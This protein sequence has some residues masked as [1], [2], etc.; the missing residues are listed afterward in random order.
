MKEAANLGDQNQL[1]QARELLSAAAQ[2]FKSCVVSSNPTVQIFISDI[3]SSIPR[4]ADR[5]VY[6]HGGKASMKS[7]F[8]S[9]QNKRGVYKN[10]MQKV[11]L[12]EAEEE[13]N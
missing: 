3:E 10:K 4:F 13:F 2:E 11:L 12:E 7:K 8:N 6:E 1:Q 5:Q 9:H